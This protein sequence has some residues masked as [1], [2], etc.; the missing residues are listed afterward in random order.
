MTTTTCGGGDSHEGGEV[1]LRDERS[2]VQ[3][4]TVGVMLNSL[5]IFVPACVC[6]ENRYKENIQ[7]REVSVAS[8][9]S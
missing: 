6:M 5:V 4:C 7:G 9:P 2:C 1:I 8:R 3:L